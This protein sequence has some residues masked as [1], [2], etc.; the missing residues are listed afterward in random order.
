MEKNVSFFVRAKVLICFT[1]AKHFIFLF[2]EIEF[3]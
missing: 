2:G 3:K 1:L